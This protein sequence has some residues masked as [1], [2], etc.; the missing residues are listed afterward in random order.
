MIPIIPLMLFIPSRLNRVREK[1]SNRSSQN[2]FNFES[3]TSTIKEITYAT[4]LSNFRVVLACI[5]G[6][7]AMI[8]ML[9]YDTIFTDRLL[10]IGVSENYIG[11]IFSICTLTFSI[12]CPIAGYLCN[13]Y[14]WLKIYMTQLAFPFTFISLIQMGPSQILNFPNTLGWIISGTAFLGFSCSLIFIPL[15]PEI[16]E[17]V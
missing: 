4:L 3:N 10:E 5:S 13:R 6:I 7:L 17:A 12:S 9:F 16:I 15:L 11:Y 8:F 2:A 14:P 1:S